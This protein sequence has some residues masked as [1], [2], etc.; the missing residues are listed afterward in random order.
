M[1]KT[2]ALRGPATLMDILGPLGQG[3]SIRPE[4]LAKKDEQRRRHVVSCALAFDGSVE[5]GRA[6]VPPAELKAE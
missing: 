3:Y 4:E 6:L 1:A 2:A 5:A